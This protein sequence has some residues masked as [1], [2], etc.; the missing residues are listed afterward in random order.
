MKSD[1]VTEEA[2]VE[3]S[4]VVV[5]FDVDVTEVEEGSVVAVDRIDGVDHASVESNL[6]EVTA[7]VVM[8]DPVTPT[9]GLSV[10]DVAVLVLVVD[11]LGTDR[12]EV[13]LV[14]VSS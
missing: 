10:D 2:W 7:R 8:V 5:L 9:S 1:A 12:V 13:N 6:V 11:V 3:S 14:V 4:V